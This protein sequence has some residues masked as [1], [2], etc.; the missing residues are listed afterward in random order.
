MRRE[1]CG[2]RRQPQK[3]DLDLKASTPRYCQMLCLSRFGS[4]GELEDAVDEGF[5]FNQQRE[6]LVSVQAAPAFLGGLGQFE[7]HGQ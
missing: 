4:G 3:Y 7:H 6:E 5:A 1:L 2:F